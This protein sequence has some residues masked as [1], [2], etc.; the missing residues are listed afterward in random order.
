MT[1]RRKERA[2]RVGGSGRKME[3]KKT[4]TDRKKK[5]SAENGRIPYLS[6]LPVRH[7]PISHL[8]TVHRALHWLHYPS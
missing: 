5:G 3:R 1:E 2:E 8:C 4:E 7:A 6:P